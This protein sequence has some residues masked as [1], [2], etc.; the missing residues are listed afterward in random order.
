MKKKIYLFAAVFL[1][2]DVIAKALV[3]KAGNVMLQR[4]IIPNFFYITLTKNTGAA[5]SFLTGYTWV[6]IVI[7]IAALIYIDRAFLKDNLNKLQILSYSLL[8]GGIF[9][10]LVDRLC[11]GYVIDFLHFR[12]FGYDFPI[13][14]FADIFIVV[15]A[16]LLGITLIRSGI[17]ENRSKRKK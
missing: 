7:A 13:F 9:G 5:F 10:N 1:A 17:D 4:V 8:I 6:F 16:V 3:V 11:F 12:I 2:I 14:N 15:G